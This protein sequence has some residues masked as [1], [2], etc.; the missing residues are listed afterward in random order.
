MNIFRRLHRSL[1]VNTPGRRLHQQREFPGRE[2]EFSTVDGGQQRASFNLIYSLFSG[3][4]NS[5]LRYNLIRQDRPAFGQA[6]CLAYL[7][8]PPEEREG[9]WGKRGARETE[10]GGGEE[11]VVGGGGGR[12]E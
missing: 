2:K 7:H 6:L 11:V 12:V 3:A 10:G 9:G 5:S 1:R 8:L 4:R